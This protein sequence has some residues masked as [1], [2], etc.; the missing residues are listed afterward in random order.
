MD[1]TVLSNQTVLEASA[2]LGVSLATLAAKGTA[3]AIAAKV[4]SLKEVRNADTVRTAYDELISELL[5]ERAEAILIAQAYK[6]ALDR[7][8]ISDEDIQSL[9]N[10]LGR[11]LDIFGLGVESDNLADENA[12]SQAIAIRQLRELISADTLKTMQL[13][14]FNYKA[15][16]GEPLTKL[17]AERIAALGK[18]A[19]GRGR[20]K[21]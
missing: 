6:D 12:R 14:G 1:A 10:T 21:K 11:V 15:A 18:S 17:C 2:Q 16:I 13:L 19:S 8:E 5:E 20:G 3:S 7:V 4:R 9:N